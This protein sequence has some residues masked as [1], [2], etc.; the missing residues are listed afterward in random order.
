MA[1]QSSRLSCGMS[2]SYKRAKGEAEANESGDRKEGKGECKF[3]DGNV[4]EKL[5]FSQP[6]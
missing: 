3:G 6:L 1:S 2:Q 4:E 5:R